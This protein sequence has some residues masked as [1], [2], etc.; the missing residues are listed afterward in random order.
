[1][2]VPLLFAKQGRDLKLLAGGG[3]GLLSLAPL[4]VVLGQG[5]RRLPTAITPAVAWLAVCVAGT[6]RHREAVDELARQVIYLLTFLGAAVALARRDLRRL[7]GLWLGAAILVGGY[8]IVQG[9]GLDPVEEFR[10][11]H[12]ESRVFSTFGNPDFLGAFLA[13]LL[14]LGLAA[15]S[16]A[17][18]TVVRAAVAGAGLLIAVVLVWTGSRGAWLGA[19]AGSACWAVLGVTREDWHRRFPAGT[20]WPRSG[21]SLALLVP[22]AVAVLLLPSVSKTLTRRTDRLDLWQGTCRMIRSAPVAGWG[23][24]RFAPEYPPF[25]PAA[26]AARMKADNTFAEHPH[27]EYLHVAVESG[28]L[29]LGLFGWLLTA[30]LAAGWRRARAGDRLAA[31]AA[32]S[33][34]AILVHIAVDRNFRLASTG[35]PFWLLAGALC[36][37]RGPAAVPHHDRKRPLHLL[38]L[39]PALLGCAWFLR[40]LLASYRVAGDTDF[41]KQAADIPAAQL[42]AQRAAKGSDP[43]YL[44]ALGNAY[45]KEGKF[46]QAVAAFRDA[47]TIDPHYAAAANNLGNSWFMMSRFDEA[48]AAYSRVLALDRGNKDA[49]FN[50]AFALFHQRKIKEAL[51]ECDALLRLDPQNPKALQLRAQLA[52]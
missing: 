17:R 19:A 41:L 6:L 22:V 28:L 45:A 49:R 26:F 5:R 40:P 21:W 25:A 13:F 10:K 4:A 38:A 47:L 43:Q 8:A 32:G 46:P 14:P 23:V 42:E 33:L 44:M 7:A 3:I 35:I 24:G 51:A 2:L 11:W 52:P 37:T 29:G 31:G 18:G 39:I 27:S 30:V 50:R 16:V 36:H 34:V 48:I 15:L 20:A 1:M 12:S 9:A